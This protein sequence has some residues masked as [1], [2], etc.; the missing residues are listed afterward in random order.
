MY[1]SRSTT[2]RIVTVARRAVSPF[3]KT[4]IYHSLRRDGGLYVMLL[5]VIAGFIIFQYI[6][7]VNNFFIGFV[8]YDLMKGM[9]GSKWVGLRYFKQ[10]FNDPF[11]FRLIKNTFLLG[12]YGLVW[13][14][15]A[16]IVLALLFNE[17]RS[18]P[19]KRF[20]QSVCYLPHF[21]STVVIVGILY[22][23]FGHFG[24]VNDFLLFLGFDRVKFVGN[25]AWFR[26]LYIGSGIWQSVGW[27]TIIYMA[28]IAGINLELYEAA[29]IDGANRRRQ[30]VH[31]TLP[32]MAPAITILLIVNVSKIISVGFQKVYLMYSPVVY[33]VADVI[34]TYVYR[35]GIEGMDFSYAGAVD[36]FSSVV[37]VL[38]IWIANWASRRLSETSFF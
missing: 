37:S 30:V 13:G 3:A 33:Q 4:K 2:R 34:K 35:R 10:F 21:I 25:P 31:I 9:W 17:L 5:P 36:F 8:K 19:F 26:T 6:P 14:F 27:G 18:H 20:V 22:K 16:P 32:G 1:P 7:M 23:I 28:A 38:L 11:F 15:P 12:F 24:V 29:I